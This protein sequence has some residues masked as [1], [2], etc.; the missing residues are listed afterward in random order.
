[1]ARW[2]SLAATLALMACGS[3]GG[4]GGNSSI[5][6]S[7][8]N[9]STKISNETSTCFS[10]VPMITS[11]ESSADVAACNLVIG[12]CSAQDQT[13]LTNAYNCLAK[14][15]PIQCSWYADGGASIPDGGAAQWDAQAAKC[16]PDAGVGSSCKFNYS[17]PSH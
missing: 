15:P 12:S 11:A 4:I 14:L 7:A 13:A 2:T 8:I 16:A 9:A 1:M 6:T 3:V 5:C 10:N 17:A